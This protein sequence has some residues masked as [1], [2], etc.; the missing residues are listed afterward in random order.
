LIGISPAAVQIVSEYAL[1][2]IKTINIG[3]VWDSHNLAFLGSVF[4]SVWTPLLPAR[5]LD[6]TPRSGSGICWMLNLSA[7]T[8][9]GSGSVQVWTNFRTGP[10]HHYAS[11]AAQ[12]IGHFSWIDKYLTPWAAQ[13]GMRAVPVP[14][15][16]FLHL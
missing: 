10:Y 12:H 6:Q 1:M 15:E 13:L 16:I 14:L 9:S 8:A 4:G 3:E 2:H 7:N 11:S 5:T